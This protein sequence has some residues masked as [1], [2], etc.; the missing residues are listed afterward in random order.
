LIE[1]HRHQYIPTLNDNIITAIVATKDSRFLTK[2]FECAI[3]FKNLDWFQSNWSAYS[4]WQRQSNAEPFVQIFTKLIMFC[5]FYEAISFLEH[6]IKCDAPHND[7]QN[8]TQSSQGERLLDT[9]LYFQSNLLPDFD[10]RNDW[11]CFN[12][13]KSSF[14]WMPAIQHYQQS[15]KWD[16]LLP[17]IKNRLRFL[18]WVHNRPDLIRLD[19]VTDDD[20]K[21]ITQ[22]NL[23][24]STICS[25]RAYQRWHQ[26]PLMEILFP[27]REIWNY[28]YITHDIEGIKW[29]LDQGLGHEYFQ[30]QSHRSHHDHDHDLPSTLAKKWMEKHVWRT[31]LLL[32][33]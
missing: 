18:A 30:S 25:Y 4:R 17:S 12:R 2:R 20:M 5:F 7:E 31:P 14:D 10:P 27:I 15:M 3:T 28:L 24:P 9:Y 6:I 29:Y 11:I 21:M 16:L 8:R 32:P 19:E 23:L 13:R 26:F 1:Q 22:W 33:P